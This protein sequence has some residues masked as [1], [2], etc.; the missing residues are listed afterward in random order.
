MKIALFV[1]GFTELEFV[2][3]LI[4]AICGKR[5]VTFEIQEQFKGSLV[6]VRIDTAPNATTHVTIVNCRSDEQVKTRL[7]DAYP[8]LVSSGYTHVIGLRD[9]YP[10]SSAD[11]PKIQAA[12]AVGIPTGPIPA[13]IHLA[14]TE[15]ESWFLDEITHFERIDSGLT[16]Q[17]ITSAG[18]DVRNTLGADWTHPAKTLDDIYRIT[19]KRYRKKTSHI[20]RTVNA[21]SLEELYV[22]VRERS[23]SFNGFLAGLEEALF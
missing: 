19:G 9:V 23:P 11:I 8:S 3:S 20:R 13:E 21:L 15:V 18:F 2:Q 16:A 22:S 12:L 10:F 17:A 1:E 6:L 14:I 5:R 4:K 7:R